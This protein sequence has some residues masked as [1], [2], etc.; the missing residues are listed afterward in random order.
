MNTVNPFYHLEKYLTRESKW[1]QIIIRSSGTN[2][3][4]EPVSAGAIH[5]SE[6]RRGKTILESLYNLSI[7]L[8]PT[9]KRQK[10]EQVTNPLN[11]D[12]LLRES[13]V[14]LRVR[15][16][17]FFKGFFS[18]F[19]GEAMFSYDTFE[20]NPLRCE[21][22]RASLQRDDLLGIIGDSILDSLRKLNE[23][24]ITPD[25]LISMI[26]GRKFLDIAEEERGRIADVEWNKKCC[27]EA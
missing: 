7:S 16:S 4:A 15:Y 8:A 5:C 25:R 23:C 12:F 24:R 22:L 21:D 27:G 9:V 11:I 20:V 14:S 6:G 18:S 3:C 13:P 17:P 19:S 1:D 10:I 26:L 2:A